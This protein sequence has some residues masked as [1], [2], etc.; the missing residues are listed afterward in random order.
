MTKARRGQLE[1]AELFTALVAC[2]VC[3]LRWRRRR[4]EKRRRAHACWRS[5]CS[6]SVAFTK[7]LL[8][9]RFLADFSFSS[10]YGASRFFLETVFFF[11]PTTVSGV[12]ISSL[13]RERFRGFLPFLRNA[14]FCDGSASAGALLSFF[15][16]FFSYYGFSFGGKGGFS[17][18]VWTFV[19]LWIVWSKGFGL[20]W[21]FSLY[22]LYGA[23]YFRRFFHLLDGLV[24][25]IDWRLQVMD[26][27]FL[28]LFLL[29]SCFFWM[30]LT[31]CFSVGGFGCLCESFVASSLKTVSFW[32]CRLFACLVPRIVFV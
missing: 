9:V 23:V 11:C 30:F 5:V 32:S 26:L 10:N 29:I 1:K 21:C 28:F 20:S 22:L 14:F 4:G 16:C 15:F 2:R 25:G 18:M 12:T 19:F 13:R 8:R 7:L 27:D 3:G 17:S 24:C 31:V 6:T